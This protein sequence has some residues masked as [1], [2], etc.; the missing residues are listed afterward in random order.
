MDIINCTKILVIYHREDNDGVCSAAIVSAFTKYIHKLILD[1]GGIHIAPTIKFFGCNY[2]ELSTVWQEHQELV[3]TMEEG[4]KLSQLE[5][6]VTSYDKIFMV[7]ISFNEMDAMEYLY[8]SMPIE[9]FVWCDHHAPVI[10]FS[11]EQ[12]NKYEFGNTPGIRRTDQS[13][14]LNTWEFMN[15]ACELDIEPSPVLVKLSDYDSWSWTRKDEYAGT[16]KDVLFAIN[17]GFTR[18]SNLKVAWFEEYIDHI[19][20]MR[21]TEEHKIEDDCLQ[22]GTTIL[23]YDRERNTRAINSHGDTEWTLGG[24]K[25]C[26]IFTTDRFNSQSFSMFEGTDIKHGLVFKR[27]PDGRWVMSAYNVS[28]DTVFHCGDYLKANYNGG[29]HK[30]AAGCTLSEEQFIKLLHTKTV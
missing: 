7:D 4:R 25:A 15:K 20:N 10:K 6:W 9:D 17:T 21:I 12:A 23:E 29:G 14:L 22:Y 24:E 13:A 1:N 5:K 30:G 3:A 26:A 16:G 28:E 2:A 27:E 8:D 18:R 19:L 11:L